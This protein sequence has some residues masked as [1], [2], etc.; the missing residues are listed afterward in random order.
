MPPPERYETRV[1]LEPIAAPSALGLLAF[2]GATFLAGAHFARWIPGSLAPLVPLLLALGGLV[3]F[4]AGMWAFK[5]RDGL[6]AA[7]H[8]VWG[9]HWLGFGTLQLLL[10][11]HVLAQPASGSPALG[12]WFLVMGALI[13][14]GALA[15]TGENAGLLSVLTLL[16]GACVVMGIGQLA[17][18]PG[19]QEAAGYLFAS[20]AVCALYTAAALLIEDVRGEPLLPLGRFASAKRKR[21]ITSG[22]REPGVTRGQ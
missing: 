20:S 18:S 16:T 12:W 13:A 11:G 8:T 7:I 2:A 3:Q 10:L 6:A 1:V 4:A 19:T 9:A 5:A 21:P 15:S 14:V 22:L 17:G